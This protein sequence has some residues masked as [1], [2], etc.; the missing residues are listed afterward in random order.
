[1]TGVQTCALPICAAKH[2]YSDTKRFSGECLILPGNGANVGDVYYYD[3]DFDAYQRTYVIHDITIL[4][5]FLNYHLRLNWK[6]INED[7]QFGSATNFIK[8]GNFKD[9]VVPF[10]LLGEQQNIVAKLD[11]SFAH[12]K[13]AEDIILKKLKNLNALKA[14]IL[15]KELQS[16][17]A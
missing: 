1:V 10:P 13:R 14:A 9:Y 2:S 12:L 15:A 16:E 3:G 8:I 11:A 5:K 17:A 7:K 4:P 6:K